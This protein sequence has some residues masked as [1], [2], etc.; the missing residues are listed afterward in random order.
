MKYLLLSLILVSE[1]GFASLIKKDILYT[2]GATELL[3]YMVYDSTGLKKK[4]GVLVVHDWLGLTDKT[5]ARA[6]QLAQLG[7]VA[8]AIDIY[9]KDSRPQSSKDAGSFAGKYKSDRKLYRE[10]LTAGLETLKKQTGVDTQKLAAIGY[11]FGGTGVIELARTG[12]NIKGIVSFHGG[13]DSPTP[14]DGKKIKAEVL[15]LH[16]ADDPFVPDADLKAFEQ[17]MREAKVDWQL[18]KYGNAVH[19]FTDK[20]AGNDNS[21]GAAYNEKADK[22]SWQDMKMFFEDLL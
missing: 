6:D 19:S 21:K 5:K 8:F 4:P 12:A 20:T 10:R 1:L 13:L 15:A 17:E 11:C 22:R 14:T 16:G 9:G 18:I 7:Y 3:G 2:Q